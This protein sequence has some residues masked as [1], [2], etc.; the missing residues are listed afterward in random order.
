MVRFTQLR[1]SA[2]FVENA[3]R[4][5]S[6]ILDYLGIEQDFSGSSLSCVADFK[7]SGNEIRCGEQEIG[8]HGSYSDQPGWHG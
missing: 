5:L 4:L 8:E 2:I 3:S 6:A 7:L 1:W